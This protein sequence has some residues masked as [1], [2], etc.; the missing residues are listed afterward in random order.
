LRIALLSWESSYTIQVGGLGVAVSGL[1]EGLAKEGH[2]VCLFTRRAPG[3]PHYMYINLVHYHACSFDWGQN[4]LE[5]ARNMS[6]AIVENLRSVE[7]YMGEFDIVHGHDWLVVDALHELKGDGHPMIL[8]Y[9]STEYG[10]NGG[11]FGDWWE[12]KEI[13][14]K[15]W[16]GGYIS[17]RVTTVS[18]CMRNELNWLYNVPFEKVDVIPNAIDRDRFKL[19]VD[20]GRV[21]ERYGIHPLAPV[22][23]FVGRLERQK[24]PDLLLEAIPKVLSRRWDAKFLFVGDG[25]MRGYL[26]WRAGELGVGHAARFLGFVPHLQYLELLNSC[27]IACLPSRNEPFGMTLLEAWAAGRPVVATDIGGFG[28]NID[29]F[30]NGLKVYTNPD[31]VAWGINYLLD[32]PGLMKKL[33]EEGARRVKDFSWE[34][35]VGKMTDAYSKV[36]RK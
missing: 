20:P 11:C 8:T 21:K 30:S 16:Y 4:V 12:F 24:G 35:V 9:H 17:D 7:R 33:S 31:S 28:E 13:S 25:G 2:E 22:V 14:G 15:E 19:D 32:S 10:R 5:L 36:L 1:A 18:N 34:N 3:Q 26:E 6:K 29:N 27:D 23:L